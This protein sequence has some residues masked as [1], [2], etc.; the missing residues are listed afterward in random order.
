MKPVL[1]D[2]IVIFFTFRFASFSCHRDTFGRFWVHADEYFKIRVVEVIDAL[3][4]SICPEPPREPSGSPLTEDSEMMFPS[5]SDFFGLALYRLEGA[6]AWGRGGAR[7]REIWTTAFFF[8]GVNLIFDLIL[9]L[10]QTWMEN[11]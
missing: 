7:G 1:L 2:F 11:D 5:Y 6:G 8:F 9:R 3:A 4:E 10:I